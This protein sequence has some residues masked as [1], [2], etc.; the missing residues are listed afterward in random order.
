MYRVNVNS[1]PSIFGTW[2]SI[3]RGVAKASSTAR[4]VSPGASARDRCR[5]VVCRPKAMNM[6]LDPGLG[7][8]EHR[9]D[10]QIAFEGLE[11][12]L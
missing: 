4:G 10:D 6:C 7:L 2:T 5:G 11:R 8:M 12:L 3:T 9:P 1:G